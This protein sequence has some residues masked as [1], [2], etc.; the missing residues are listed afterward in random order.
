MHALDRRKLPYPSRGKP[1][2]EFD[3][4]TCIGAARVW[5]AD[6]GGEEFKKAIG[7]AFAK[8]RDGGGARSTTS[9]TSWFMR[10]NSFPAPSRASLSPALIFR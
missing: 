7:G 9:K 1:V 8:R 4:R 3:G 5:I 10:P 2:E 6:I